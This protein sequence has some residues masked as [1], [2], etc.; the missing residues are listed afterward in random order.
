MEP[1]QRKFRRLP[2]EILL[3]I[4]KYA[5]SEGLTICDIC[6]S[7]GFGDRKNC[8]ECNNKDKTPKQIIIE[9]HIPMVIMI[10][11]RISPTSKMKEVLS[12]GLLALTEAVEK[13]PHDVKSISG[14]LHVYVVREL[15]QFIL[16]DGVIIVPHYAPPKYNWLRH[17]EYFNGEIPVPGNQGEVEVNDLI[18]SVCDTSMHKTI[19]QCLMEGGYTGKDLANRCN[20]SMGRISQVKSKLLLK[21][22][23]VFR[24]D[25]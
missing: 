6:V 21:L 8:K 7:S 23:E 22:W 16:K 18:E 5:D 1:L 12:A 20:V 4:K 13:M 14:Y 15:K 24:N 3:Q 19:L 17:I 11:N 25:I 2:N 10:V 9:S